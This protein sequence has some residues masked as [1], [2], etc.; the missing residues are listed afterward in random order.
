MT[1]KQ[2]VR[3]V[4][5][6]GYGWFEDEDTFEAVDCDWCD[7]SGYVYRDANGVD[8][9]IPQ[10]DYARIA[11]RLETL[12]AQRLR[13]LGYTGSAKHPDDQAVRRDDD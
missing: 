9:K 6:D 1:D 8:S 3:C 7:G 4:S 12:D 2:L 5:C 11:S 13:E 10:A